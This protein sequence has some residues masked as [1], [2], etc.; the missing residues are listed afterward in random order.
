MS[1]AGIP[2]AG[3]STNLQSSNT[4]TSSQ[5]TEQQI[6]YSPQVKDGDHWF[7]DSI[8]APKSQDFEVSLS[9]LSLENSPQSQ[10]KIS[11]YAST[12]SEQNPDHHL[13][14]LINGHLVVDERWDGQGWQTLD[15]IIPA[16]VLKEG[17]NQVTISLPGDTGAPAD[18][19]LLNWIE[20]VYNRDFQAEND[21]LEFNSS[22]QPQKLAGFRGAVEVFDTSDGNHVLRWPSILPAE[23][24]GLVFQG[25]A[26]HRYL[27]V[28]PQGFLTPTIT[29]AVA[30]SPDLRTGVGG[31]DY[32]AIGPPDL[33]APLKPLLEWR[34][35]Q[36][37]K[38]VEVPIDSV[39]DQF[40]HRMP[41]PE[42]I[43]SFLNYAHQNW[44]PA[45]R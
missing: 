9:H 21:C 16:A 19:D 20:I 2:A 5:H 39:Y 34:Q 33:L 14:A 30:S 4:Y 26:G 38:V 10:L 24:G 40:T 28:G 17:K 6:I 44:K 12:E 18:I 36:G 35:K 31:A 37:L 27:V 42:A 29:K 7:W 22:G 1:T 25:L 23:N 45:P 3:N 11:V 43:R 15:A 13:Q 8:A 41:E 32:I